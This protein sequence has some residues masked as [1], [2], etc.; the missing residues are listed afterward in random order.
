MRSMTLVAFGQ[1][2]VLR[3][4]DPPRPG[5]GEV[6]VR[7]LACG[8]CR[9]DLKIVDGQM[10]FSARQRLPHVPGHEVAGVVADTGEGVSVPP[11][12][13][14]VVYNYWGCGRCPYCIAGEENL[15]DALRGWVGFTTP[16]GFQEFLTAP[17]SHVLPL[18]DRV[19]AVQGAAMSCALGTAYRAVLTRGRVQAGETAVVLGTG[20]VGIHA[21][22]FAR[23]AGARPVAVDVAG[24]K[25]QA[26]REAGAEE[27]VLADEA[28]PRVRAMT[29]GRG[30]DLVVDCVGSGETTGVAVALLRK[31]G[32]IVQVGYT[33]EEGHHPAL[34]TDRMALDEVSIIG[35]RYVTRPELARAI[36]LVARGQVRPVVSEVLDLSQANE[37]LAMVRADRAVGRIVLAVT[38][39]P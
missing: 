37:A 36:E 3:D 12:Q 32:R 25:L 6:L 30:A 34:P 21:V 33:T 22:Q 2:L 28:V 1:P 19:S 10:P 16:G 23:A 35:S 18:P 27:A 9:T 8:V 4:V 26:A 17:A 38:A 7:V 5:P 31:G 29:A 15:C 20:G 14:V 11:G 13:R 24:A 39:A